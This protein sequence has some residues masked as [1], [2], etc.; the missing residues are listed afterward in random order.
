M[1]GFGIDQ[2]I[3]EYSSVVTRTKFND[4]MIVCLSTCRYYIKYI[5]Q[6]EVVQR[7]I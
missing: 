3:I 7:L 6:S 2:Y 5:T 1:G 4:L